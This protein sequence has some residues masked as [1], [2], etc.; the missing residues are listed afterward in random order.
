MDKVALLIGV[1]EYQHSFNPLPGVVKDVEA[2]QKVLQN[3]EIGG[4][5]VKTL[6]NPDLVKMRTA[7]ETLFSGRQRDDLVLLYFS[8]HG[9]TDE[10]CNLYFA[11]S[12]TQKKQFQSTGVEASFVH[13]IMENSR[14]RRQVVILDCCFS[15]AFPNKGLLA[16]DRGFIDLKKELGGEGR[17]ILT[18][19]TAWDYCFAGQEEN[20][21]IYTR[22]LVE[23]IKTGAADRDE[24]GWI[25][26]D[27]LHQ[28]TKNKVEEAAP[29]M[30]PEI[31]AFKEGYSIKLA[32]APVDDPKRQ[33]RQEVGF[34]VNSGQI[35]DI[36][37][38]ALNRL[39]N[40]L[41]L[42]HQEAEVIESEVLKPFKDH[43]E[44][45]DEY[46]EEFVKA[47][48]REYPISDKTRQQLKGFQKILNLTDEN[49]ALIENRIIEEW[50]MKKRPTWK[51][52]Y[53]LFGVI[54]GS[55]LTVSFFVW[56]INSHK[57]PDYLPQQP[58]V[59]RK[60]AADTFGAISNVPEGTFKYSGSGAWTPIHP[61]LD[62]EIKKI[63]NQFH[64]QFL[65]SDEQG[66]LEI[67]SRESIGM[68]LD[69]K[70]DFAL[71]NLPISDKE[72]IEAK[73]NGFTIEQ[74]PVGKNGV[75]VAVN[76]KLN[77]SKLTI[78]ELRDI[79][80]G[81]IRNWKEVGGSDTK[82]NIYTSG[83]GINS[84]TDWIKNILKIQNPDNLAELTPTANANEAFNKVAKDPGGISLSS[85]SLVVPQCSIKSLPLVGNGNKV[86]P[87]YQENNIVRPSQ[88]GPG[89]RNRVNVQAIYS[90]DYPLTNDLYVL[91]KRNGQKEEQAGIAYAN[92]LNTK[93]GQEMIKQLQETG[94][95]DDKM[96][97]Q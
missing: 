42:E 3:P 29:A 45:L 4:F 68:L 64:L 51:I 93:Q 74:I 63:H 17:A 73:K 6:L 8:G 26:V 37:R 22:Y 49:I 70:L 90:G 78:D 55:F 9:I 32:K 65:T 76:P 69:G 66:K 23:G 41:S 86:V 88:C 96:R 16:K 85:T 62:S 83:G 20:L 72:K 34:W 84:S 58:E 24:D 14:S 7:I 77:I 67:G 28:Y 40:S 5:E 81:K 15:G 94:N 33:Y 11:I 10:R 56:Y 27:E 48:Q 80:T 75:A 50:E 13:R 43:E 92:L 25:S 2:M 52:L 46:K 59:S 95:I 19:T 71:S 38:K 57:P 97:R 89:K 21:S 1:S 61:K 53:L 18:S 79:Y 60:V 47:I 87:P 82:I 39:R 30:K 35:P 12:S 44:K 91:I 31:I 36:G 54:I